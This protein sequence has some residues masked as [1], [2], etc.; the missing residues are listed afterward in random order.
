MS[1]LLS[2]GEFSQMTHI[3]VKALRHYDDLGLLQPAEVDPSSGYRRYA[4]SQVPTAHVIRRFR[5]L[6]MPLEQ[7]RVVLDASDVVTRNEVIVEHLQRMQET[8]ERT[9]ATVASLQGLLDGS[10]PALP[11]AHRSAPATRAVAIRDDVDWG[12]TEQWL[13]SA[14]E[15]L[16]GII[17]STPNARAGPDA[18]LYSPAFFE[19]HIG[20][21]IAFVPITD[22]VAATGRAQLVDIPA[23]ELA[24]L[25][26]HGP[27]DDLDQAYGALGTFVAERVLAA[28]G[29]I[30]ENYLV[31]ADDTDDPAALLTE[32]CWPIRADRVPMIQTPQE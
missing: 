14:L 24:V 26:H 9:Q 2:I 22:D 16:G 25:T 6:D 18:A 3:S 19:A 30:R 8:L 11:V 15:E 12:D 32:V 7:I 31:T 4:T 13:T 20:E 1:V 10:Q 27:F 29:P 21:V 23:A 17:D 5:D 28:D